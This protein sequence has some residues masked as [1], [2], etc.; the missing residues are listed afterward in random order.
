[1]PDSIFLFLP[2]RHHGFSLIFAVVSAIIISYPL[3][4]YIYLG[5]KRKYND[6]AGSL[7]AESARLYLYTFQRLKVPTDVAMDEFTKFYLLW[8]GR[9]F[10]I[11]PS[12]FLVVIVL[13][14]TFVIGETSFVA[15]AK[16]NASPIE[17]SNF[18]TLPDIAVASIAG[19]YAFVSWD[20]ILRSARRTLT[21]ADI[22]GST[23]RIMIAIPLGYSL[24]SI[25][26]ENLAA[27]VAFAIAAF[28]IEATQTILQRLLNRQFN[29]ELGAGTESD[30][31]I[32]L[33]G[34]DKNTADRLVEA[35]ITTI[36]QM[37]YCDPVQTCMRT[38][39]NFAVVSDL[40][41]QA[42]AWLYFENDLTKLRKFG[43]RGAREIRFLM[44]DLTKGDPDAKEL[45]K[46]LVQSASTYL[47]LSLDKLK[48]AFQQ[49]AN[50]P[51]TE[52]LAK[53]WTSGPI[54]TPHSEIAH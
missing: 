39:L 26:K 46:E 19:A 43:L 35:D 47:G 54:P 52:F 3:I 31:V 45:A 4:N 42:L 9:R 49:I 24:S 22:L 37:A 5:W 36:L 53:A 13:M 12:A 48:N 41:A 40:S 44:Q 15:L 17:T 27:F 33:S 1:M 32:N 6:I 29:V 7:T 2:F 11:V 25:V 10:L 8:Y 20:I 50:D 14:F 34:I 18:M 16:S 23:I 51:H 28:P 38:S 21:P 30:Q